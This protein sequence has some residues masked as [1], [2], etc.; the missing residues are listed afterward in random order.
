MCKMCLKP[1][2]HLLQNDDSPIYCSCPCKLKDVIADS[3]VFYYNSDYSRSTNLKC[4]KC[5]HFVVIRYA[6]R[7]RIVEIKDVVK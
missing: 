3:E 4:S 1:E 6:Q 2:S 7:V 5:N